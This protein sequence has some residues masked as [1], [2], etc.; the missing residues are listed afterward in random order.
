MQTE[1]QETQTV[2]SPAPMPALPSSGNPLPFS[3]LAKI[4]NIQA[5]NIFIKA[6]C[7]PKNIKFYNKR[8]PDAHV[9]I[10]AQGEVVGFDENNIATRYIAPASGVVPANTR[11]AWYTMEDSVF[12]CVHATSETDP[13]V[14]DKKY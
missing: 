1:I 5:E 9:V 3:A 7:V 4:K 10:L 12:Y 6:S 11:W 2:E 8:T 14:L 13:D